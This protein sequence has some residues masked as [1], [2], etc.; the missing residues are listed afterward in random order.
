MLR[1]AVESDDERLSATRT[2]SPSAGAATRTSE[3]LAPANPGNT[4][5][6]P[7]SLGPS[8]PRDPERYQII[9]EH[10]RGGLGRVS[11]A[12]D[13]ELGR[14]IAIKELISRGHVSEVRFLREALITAR[15]EHPGIVPVH[16]AGRWPDGTPFYAMKLVAGR[17][18]RDLI[19]E[20]TTVEE[21]IGLLHHV[22]A[23]ADAIA[24][25]HGRNI[26]HRDLKP[27]NVI[28]G[29]FGET[30]VIDWGLAKDLT[31]DDDSS[32]GGGPLRA[33][34]DEG[35][36]STGSVLG[37]PAYMAPE[38]ARGEHVDQ[39]ADVFAIG[40]MLWEL[41]AVRKVLPGVPHHRHRVLRRAGIDQDLVAII[42]KALDPAPVRRYPDAGALAA[43]LKAFKSGARIAARSYSL[44]AMLGH[45]TRRH[46]A[47]A[48]SVVAAIALAAAGSV[49][50]VRNI[51]TERDRAETSNNNL[52]LEHAQLLLRDDPSA[53]FDLLQSYSGADTQRLA[54]LRAQAQGLGLSALRTRPHTQ[55]IWFAH[56]LADGSVVTL[57][58][59]G[60]VAK[61]LVVGPT[62]GPSRIIATG[63]TPQATLDYAD[64][65]HLLAY[66][67]DATT[68]CLLDVEA[69]QQRPP[70]AGSAIAPVALAFSPSG[71]QLAAISAHGE[72]S[73]WQLSNDG[74]P[75]MRYQA[76]LGT[77]TAI[78]FIDEHTIAARAAE[79]IQ[80]IHLDAPGQ[81]PGALADL[82]VP[83][84][85]TTSSSAE[86]H[87]MVVGTS[88]GG[89]A[90]ID[91]QRNEI[92]RREAICNGYVRGLLIVPHRS[93]IA[94]ACQDGNAGLWD[95]DHNKRSVLGYLEGGAAAVSGT[96]D[97][98]YL[99]VGGVNGRLLIYDFT[100]Q[101]LSSYLGH[102]TRITVLLPPSPGSPY[103]I[104]ADTSGLMR[105]WLPPETAARVA[106]K[107]AVPMSRAIL[108]P[109]HGPLIGT[110]AGTTIPWYTHDGASG[111]LQGHKP[112]HGLFA[113]SYTWPRFALFGVDDEVELWSFEPR[114]VNR[115][116]K[117][118]QVPTAAVFRSDGAHLVVGSR[119]GSI[120]EWSTE[121]DT[122][123]EVG[124]VR[125][126]IEIMRVIPDT[127]MIA[128][129]TASG[130]V[131]LADQTSM[132]ELGQEASSIVTANR[133]NDSRWLAVGTS[134]GLVRLYDLATG[135]ATTVRRATSKIDFVEFS[136]DSRELV[137]AAD[138]KLVT[139]ATARTG[140]APGGPGD[141]AMRW[142]EI[143]LSIRGLAFSP[144]NKW[145]AATCD[146]GD[147]WFYQR[148]HDRWVYLSTGTANVP[149]GRF[150]DDGAYFAASDASGRALLVDMHAHMFQ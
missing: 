134:R 127:G 43:D 124:T 38:Q 133:S 131:W 107:S 68:I 40:A 42:D 77:G 12:H 2:A 44:L 125:E 45:W 47:L 51:A 34:R 104:S 18:L 141:P 66:A 147:I 61:T 100:T 75:A 130:A 143:E 139:I 58:A 112:Q 73:I 94:Y 118:P 63:V 132:R 146:H 27:A 80:I 7:R 108:L 23:V 9:G 76:K 15:L 22:I 145:F 136:P 148:E 57:G 150:S 123:H 17:S 13:R 122:H 113:M 72:T 89:I 32:I 90:I 53:A 85:S 140:R 5:A 65:R 46:R 31:S 105:A 54:M 52:I 79:R 1:H 138:D 121:D 110:E 97:G 137:T 56:A 135:E 84:A 129:T 49:L 70:P 8:Q 142:H 95:V 36:T 67:C 82:S 33:T 91:T 14:D 78:C 10:G 25:A 117:T 19:A 88:A 11:R 87:L 24:Y 48:I 39:R 29:D 98:R 21:R 20:R 30:I 109:N 35:L 4:T 128:F 69:E 101:M 62:S 96:A 81:P 71:D 93:E 149:F 106:I 50:Y 103:I 64:A 116:L 28:V 26:I 119:D 60:T 120:T 99:L 59:D 111:E 3:P 55:V 37:T 144:D 41:C 115:T 6:E 83:G 86:L 102:M 92:M 114:S 126:P 16:E 74:P